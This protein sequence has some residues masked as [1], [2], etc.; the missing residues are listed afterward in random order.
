[1]MTDTTRAQWLARASGAA[2]TGG[3]L[4]ILCSDAIRTGHWELEHGLLPIVVAITIASGHLIGSAVREWRF[5]SAVGFV[6]LFLLGTAAT[7]YNSVGR[8]AATADRAALTADDHNEARASIERDLLATRKKLSDAEFYVAWEIAGRPRDKSG[9]P[10]L[11]GKPTGT[12]GCGAGCKGW[13]EQ[14]DKQRAEIARLEA[15]HEALGPATIASPK[16]DR[17]A[18]VAALFGFQQDRTKEVF[19]LVEPFLYALLFELAA[20]VAFGFG[21]AHRATRKPSIAD[22]RQTSFPPLEIGNL[23]KPSPANDPA[24]PMPPKPGNR[25]PV[26]TKAAAEADIIELMGRRETI[27]SQDAFADRWGVGKGTVS[28]WLKDF[29]RRGLIHRETVGRCKM[30]ASA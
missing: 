26:S 3:A 16:A 6:A 19:H 30:V 10:M 2:A 5:L 13:Q 8:Q 29:E 4:A 7:V 24:P 28:K 11:E 27:P 18:K 9:K 14:A 22:S 21:F 25:R 17:A 1:M 23:G 20:I 15:R 12:T